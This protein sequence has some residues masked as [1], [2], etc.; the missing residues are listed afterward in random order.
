MDFRPFIIF[1]ALFI[2]SMTIG[3]LIERIKR[4][5]K[6]NLI[7]SFGT[8]PKNTDYEIA[9]I[10]NYHFYTEKNTDTSNQID[11]ITWNDLDMDSIFKRINACHS[12]VGEEYLY[13]T[14]HEQQFDAEKL[15]EREKL[16]EYLDTHPKQRVQIQI[17]LTKLGKSQ[18]NG[19]SAYIHNPKSKLLK[20]PNL[21]RLLAVIPIIAIGI[22]F[23]NS[24]A[25]IMLTVLS[26]LANSIIYFRLKLKMEQ[27]LNTISYFSS[28]LWSSRKIMKIKTENT[29]QFFVEMKKHLKSFMTIRRVMSQAGKNGMSEFLY[30]LEYIKMIFLYD[31][32][33]YNSVMGKI[34]KESTAFR[35]LYEAFGEIDLAMC[36]LSFRKSISH[37]CIPQFHDTKEIAFE[38]LYHL[39]VKDP[40]L[41][42]DIINSNSIITGPNAS[43]KSTF[44][45][46]LAI[47]GILA[48]TIHTCTAN[49]FALRFSLVMTSMA[50]RDDILL[51][52]SYFIS[53]I[54]SLK[55]IIDK[56]ETI[57]CTC[58]I[59]EILRGTNT[60]ERIAASSSVLKY[61][62]L[63]D[64][65]CIVASHD[66]EL[67]TIMKKLYDNYHFSERVEDD[68]ITFDYQLHNGSATT[69]NA[70]KLLE[71]MGFD[72]QSVDH[73]QQAAAN[74]DKTKKWANI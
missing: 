39:L 29:G 47:N 41:N 15:L 4:K 48:Q 56:I 30:L 21:Y 73:A 58:Y 36:V 72:K 44:A 66:I 69:R 35:A 18:F 7:K 65:L 38:G 37:F 1:I 50:Q 19:L 22:I 46:A 13:H 31:I 67:T 16:I 70:I 8:P 54:K 63:K 32:N 61:L 52:D 74:F 71:F 28:M 68:G 60:I 3:I 57:F 42:S 25:G 24:F 53:E 5:T 12:S 55:R 34:T 14:L 49:T 10:E 2:I 62:S 20:Y 33:K 23:F 43:G 6:A 59:D 45:K 11:A 26:M 64:C 51:G 9:S 40:K 27:E 17:Y